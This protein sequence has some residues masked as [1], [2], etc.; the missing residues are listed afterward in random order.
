ELP[1]VAHA[2]AV[3]L[4]PVDAAQLEVA[5]G[6]AD[7]ALR[8]VIDDRPGESRLRVSFSVLREAAYAVAVEHDVVL[9]DE[10]VLARGHLD[11]AIHP[12]RVAE[13]HA[14]AE[15]FEVG[16]LCDDTRHLLA[17]GAWVV[18]NRDLERTVRLSA[19]RRERF[20]EERGTVVAQHDD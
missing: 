16:E 8:P 3:Y 13:V 20:G 19:Q 12:G 7:C 2:R 6:A 9:R 5:P 4:L 1:L 18:N 15:E 11:A 17:R 10:R 14:A